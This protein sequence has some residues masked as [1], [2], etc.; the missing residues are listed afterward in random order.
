MITTRLL[1]QIIN[2]IFA[3]IENNAEEVTLLDQVIGDGD[4]V[5]NLQR[6]LKALVL[7]QEEFIGLSWPNAWQKI[8]MIMMSS[9]GGASGSLYATLFM[10]LSKASS[11]TDISFPG[12]VKA[13]SE[14]VEAVKKRGKSEA[15]EKTLLDVYIPVSDYLSTVVNDEPDLSG[16]LVEVSAVAIKGMESTR[17]MLATKG[18][19]SFL[20]ARSIGHIDAGAKTAQLMICTIVDVLTKAL[21]TPV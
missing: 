4:H 3:V 9:V 14:A 10:A 17:N 8:G 1:P 21:A 12:F 20:E 11:E 6:G 7:Q 16:I 15:G 18:R 13:F 5:T 19:A 2:N